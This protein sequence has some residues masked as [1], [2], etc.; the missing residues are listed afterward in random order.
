MN[1]V[2]RFVGRIYSSVFSGNHIQPYVTCS[3]AA[4]TAAKTVDCA[5]FVLETGATI[6]VKFTVANTAA[7]PTLNVNGTGAKA[8]YYR[9]AAITASYLG[10]NHTYDFIYNGTQYDLVGSIDTN[11][12]THYTS[13]LYAGT[14]T[15]ANATTTNGNTKITVAD[16][17]TARDSVT[18]IG[19]GGT[20]IT[21]D[22]SGNVTVTSLNAPSYT[23]FTGKPI[24]N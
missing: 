10:A 22:A 17:S 16:N 15:A 11:S 7:N 13:H 6:K 18:L 2:S 5:G 20:T 8:I 24:A 4:G 14:G 1:G 9:G 3:T 19:A 21:S 12:D 23:S